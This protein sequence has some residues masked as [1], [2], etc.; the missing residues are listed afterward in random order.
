MASPP[1]AQA[2]LTLELG[3]RT[4]ISRPTRTAALYWPTRGTV[5]GSMRLGPRVAAMCSC[6]P[7]TLNWPLLAMRTPM[8][9]RLRVVDRQVGDRDGLVGGNDGKLGVAAGAPGRAAVHHVFSDEAFDLCCHAHVHAGD[10]EL[11][12]WTRPRRAGE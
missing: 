12:N 11:G 4:S 9:S 8:L 5:S 10:I 2:L 1:D 3:P 6:S 7:M